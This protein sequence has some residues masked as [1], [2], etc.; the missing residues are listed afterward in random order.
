MLDWIPG[1]RLGA[2]MR[3][4]GRYS[5]EIYTAQIIGL[6]AIGGLWSTLEPDE[7]EDDV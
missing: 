6:A 1:P 3:F 7:G 2:L 5:L 4:S